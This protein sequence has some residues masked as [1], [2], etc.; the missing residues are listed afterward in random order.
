MPAG[1]VSDGILELIANELKNTDPKLMT[2]MLECKTDINNGSCDFG[3]LDKE[4]FKSLIN[5]VNLA[6]NRF[7]NE[8]QKTFHDPLFL[9]GFLKHFQELISLLNSDKRAL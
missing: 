8:G 2:I 9:P 3:K 1:W 6:F 5:A 7:K 4:T